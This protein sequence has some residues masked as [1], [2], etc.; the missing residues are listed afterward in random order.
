MIPEV[1]K[2]DYNRI[3]SFLLTHMILIAVKLQTSDPKY[4]LVDKLHLRI[5]TVELVELLL[6]RSLYT[7][8]MACF[9]LSIS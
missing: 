4:V 1:R 8:D 6:Y 2:A 5:K 7:L 9:F 3:K